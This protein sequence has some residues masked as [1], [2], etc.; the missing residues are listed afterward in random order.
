MALRLFMRMAVAGSLLLLGMASSPGQETTP[1]MF[2]LNV[3]K[4]QLPADTAF[5]DISKGRH[6][7]FRGVPDP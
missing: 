3:G 1:K 6:G 7:S 4:G 2:L 5:G